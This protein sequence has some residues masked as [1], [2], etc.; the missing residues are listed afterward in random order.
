MLLRPPSQTTLAPSLPAGAA[1]PDSGGTFAGK[2]ISVTVRNLTFEVVDNRP[3]EK[4]K[5][6]KSGKKG[7]NADDDEEAATAPRS[8]KKLDDPL[9]PTSVGPELVIHG[10]SSSDEGGGA[11][12]IDLRGNV[13]FPANDDPAASSSSPSSS[14][15]SRLLRALGAATSSSRKPRLALL[16][17]VTAAFPA[18]R[19]TA[20]M[21]PSG[22]GKSTL[23][24]LMSGRKTTGR[25][26]R[27]TIL[28]AG[29][30][31]SAPFLRRYAGYVEQFDTLL[32][33]L[34]PREMLLYTAELKRPVSEPRAAKRE[35][36]E[37][38][39]DKLALRS[40][41][42][43]VVGSALHKGISGG[44]AKRTNIGIALVTS[45]RV[46]FLGELGGDLVA[47][48]HLL[49]F[50]LSRRAHDPAHNPQPSPPHP[51]QNSKTD[52]PTSGLDSFT[53]NEVMAVVRRLAVEDGTTI[54]STIHSPTAY[55]FS[56]FHDL[57]LLVA[58][59]TVY[60]GPA[61]R[62]ADVALGQLLPAVRE[63]RP[64]LV[65]A[66][67]EGNE[68]LETELRSSVAGA[69]PPQPRQSAH[70]DLPS[71]GG[72]LPPR[73]PSP[74]NGGREP[75]DPSTA[76][77]TMHSVNP[78][79]MLLDL[80]TSADRRDGAGAFADA[81]AAC[82]ERALGDAKVLRVE[83]SSRVDL[84]ESVVKELATRRE[85]VTP[86][87]WAMLQ[88]IRFRTRRN[89][90]DPEFIGPRV[91]DKIILSLI[92]VTLYLNIGKNWRADNYIN[93]A[94]VLFMFVVMPA[95][96]AA[97]YVPALFL[98]RGLFQRER[99]DGLYT[100]TTYLAYKMFDELVIGA[101]G[102]FVACAAVFY[103]VGLAGSLMLFWLTYFS[104]MTVGVLLA[105]CIAS[106][107]PTMDVANCALPGLVSTFLFFAGFL[108]R[109]EDIPKWWTWYSYC[110]PLRYAFTANLVNHFGERDPRFL[111]GKTVLEYFGVKGQS[112]W[113][114][115]G[116]IW[117]FSAGLSVVTWGVLHRNF[118]K[119]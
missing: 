103:G 45:P 70:A 96:S 95:F 20:L 117:A 60:Y 77:L 114:N 11:S 42:D 119:R 112:G 23:L 115:M 51:H 14:R 86:G 98:E 66:L 80:F 68:A 17:D 58:G 6:K 55:A 118:V 22:S 19:L 13:L 84:P 63:A 7:G 91:G 30:K 69:G 9:A 106:L 21:G 18:G 26:A 39:L 1:P 56:L 107:A 46:L 85:T 65:A 47:E 71:P 75:S 15:T 87:W 102:S 57:L 40:C 34:T 93:M 32:P 29:Q 105:F 35:A 97:A 44:Q 111:G 90:V 99:A 82:P 79:E 52:E 64:D 108:F 28:F 94:A 12:P 92:I 72:G 74:V 37:A 54:I 48:G 109:F 25:V 2:G 62:A 100:V 41:A 89:Y 43:V 61:R 110:D 78:A 38:V 67:T 113:A 104:I 27:G 76:P 4:K 49:F 10:P 16:T 81:W 33:V 8:N 73:H 24:D 53:A 83:A 5:K 59:R 50:C 3:Q 101:V 116:V 31:A 36:V 88:M